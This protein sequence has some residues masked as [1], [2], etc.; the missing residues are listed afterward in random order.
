MT[1]KTISNWAR[2]NEHGQMLKQVVIHIPDGKKKNGKPKFK[3]STKHIP[4]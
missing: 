4:V 3:S 2:K 1:T